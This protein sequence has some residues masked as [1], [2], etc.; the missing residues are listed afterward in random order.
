MRTVIKYSTITLYV[1]HTQEGGID[2][3]DIE[4]VGTGGFKGTT[5]NRTLDGE[6]REHEDYIFGKVKGHTRWTDL[7]HLTEDDPFLKQGWRSE[8]SEGKVS[9]LIE[10]YFTHARTGF[11]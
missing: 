11:H 7:D 4:Q 6:T 8:M 2:H 5:E 1:K 10:Y 3:I 9:S